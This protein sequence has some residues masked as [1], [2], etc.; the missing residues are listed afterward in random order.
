MTHPNPDHVAKPQ[1]TIPSALYAGREFRYL[2]FERGR[3]DGP[4]DTHGNPNGEDECVCIAI[5]V[6]PSGTIDVEGNI[7]PADSQWKADHPHGIVCITSVTKDKGDFSQNARV[8]PMQVVV[9]AAERG[10]PG[11]N[12]GDRLWVNVAPVEHGLRVG[13]RVDVTFQTR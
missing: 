2:E 1:F 3:G 9:G 4:V 11:V 6:P 8:G 10:R 7:N 13:M 12:A 5:V